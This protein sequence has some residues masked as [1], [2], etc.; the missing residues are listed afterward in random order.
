LVSRR[1]DVEEPS[2]ARTLSY[3]ISTFES[4]EASNRVEE[5]E[6]VNDNRQYTQVHPFSSQREGERGWK[7]ENNSLHRPK[8]QKTIEI[9]DL[10]DS[11]DHQPS[12]LHE[13]EDKDNEAEEEEYEGSDE[14]YA[15]SFIQ[16]TQVYRETEMSEEMESPYN[17]EDYSESECSESETN[18]GSSGCDIILAPF[19]LPVDLGSTGESSDSCDSGDSRDSRDSRDSGDSG[20]SRDSGDSDDSRYGGDGK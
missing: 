9:L 14:D 19:N 13:V 10:D 2:I 4:L 7:E 20:D 8:K 12:Y 16:P 17:L 15:R 1:E 18:S 11:S 5:E 3:N 6:K